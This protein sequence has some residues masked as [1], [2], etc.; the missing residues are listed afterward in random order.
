MA[1]VVGGG[2]HK[3]KIHKEFCAPGGNAFSRFTGRLFLDVRLLLEVVQAK[4]VVLELRLRENDVVGTNVKL[5][6][7]RRPKA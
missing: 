7:T 2:T 4:W 5:M 6:L 1:V 3:A